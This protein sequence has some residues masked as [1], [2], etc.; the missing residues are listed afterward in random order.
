MTRWIA[1]NSAALVAVFA[2]AALLTARA[3]RRAPTAAG[4]VDDAPARV[5]DASGAEIPVRP[6]SRIASASTIS[7][8]ALLALI[9]PPRILAFTAHIS[10][11]DLAPHRF[12]GKARI[13]R[14]DDLEGIVALEPDLLVIS[15]FTDPRRVARLRDAGLTVLDLGEMRGLE[16]YLANVR[17]LAAVLGVPERGERYAEGFARRMRQVAAD[18][19]REAR[20]TAIYLGAHGGIVFGGTRDTSYFDVLES[21]GL[22]DLAAAKYRGWPRL[23]AEQVLSLDPEVLVTQEGMRAVFCVDGALGRLR[24]CRTGQVVEAPAA[25]LRDAGEGMLDA[26]EWLRE[27]VYPRADP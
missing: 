3:D 15:T 13:E 25:L 18:V 12:E 14:I 9:E 26:A 20:K 23:D 21:A 5:I 11:E 19:P 4:E 10:G 27:A 1:A 7:D 22:V 6:Y 24:A 2:V 16:S 8:R 17:L